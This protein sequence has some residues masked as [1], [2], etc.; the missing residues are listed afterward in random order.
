MTRIGYASSFFIPLLCS[1]KSYVVIIAFLNIIILFTLA[2]LSSNSLISQYSDPGMFKPNS[3]DYFRTL[4]LGFFSP[5]LLTFAKNFLFNFGSRFLLLNMFVDFPLN[6]WLF[7]LIIF[8]LA[9]PQLQDANQPKN[10]AIEDKIWHIIPKQSYI[11]GTSWSLS[12][13]LICV[14]ENLYTYQEVP[15]PDTAKRQREQQQKQEEDDTIRTNIS[16][17][18]CMDVR[19]NSSNISE[20][21][22]YHD[23]EQI[24]L[25]TQQTSREIK[26]GSDNENPQ[27]TVIV[28]FNNNSMNFLNDIE[29]HFPASQ[30]NKKLGLVDSHIK[31]FPEITKISTLWKQLGLLNLVILSNVLLTIGQALITSIYF[32]YVPKH[33]VLFTETVIY[34]GSRTF[35]FFLLTVITPFTLLNFITHIIIFFWKEESAEDFDT[36]PSTAN[37]RQQ[38]ESLNFIHSTNDQLFVMNSIYTQD[39]LLNNEEQFKLLH[40]FK[41]IMSAWR[42]LAG[43]NWFMVSYMVLWGTTVFILGALATIKQ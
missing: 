42:C 10:Q 19:R 35:P 39:S 30:G 12:E 20:N 23:V 26:Y 37:S 7:F 36:L 13:L 6:D 18:K 9:Y 38:Q 5:F 21:V 32:I 16:L 28:D 40:I 14:I 15:S 29:S 24:P 43:K 27:N 3:Q 33:S 31:F 22:Y 11:F 1:S 8:C 2:Y 25:L 34:F 41:K 17:S 4:L